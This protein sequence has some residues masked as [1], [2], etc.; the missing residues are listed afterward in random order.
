VKPAAFAYYAP[1]SVDEA[2]ALLATH[3][4]DDGRILAGGQSLVPM[5]AYRLARPAHLIDINR[6]SELGT[7]TV[8]DGTVRIGAAVRHAAFY[9]APIPGPT[10]ALLRNVV[11]HIA[12]HPIRVRGTFG[13]SLAHA[14]PA[15]EWCCVAALLDAE[16][17]AASSASARP[18][19]IAGFFRGPMATDVREHELITEIRLPLLADGARCAFAEFGRRTGDFAMAMVAASYRVQDGRI[20]EPRVAVGGVEA[21]PRRIP[22][23][24][25]VL[26]GAP[27]VTA[28]FARAAQ[29]AASTV[30]PLDDGTGE[31][32]F[33][34][35]LLLALVPQALER[36]A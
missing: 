17:M 22:E 34:R 31:G 33:R 8:A 26:A 14:D 32:A 10:G 24:E 2:L 6:I 19:P 13:G 29:A 18:I 11:H 3:G 7:L 35:D 4:P 9:D 15:S 28:T 21:H 12:D 23:A 36:A 30:V 20:A 16:V 25:A 1:Q 5:M 27:P